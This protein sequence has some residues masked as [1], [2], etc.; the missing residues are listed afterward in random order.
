MIMCSATRSA[1]G[2]KVCVS[3]TRGDSQTVKVLATRHVPLIVGSLEWTLM[4]A[5]VQ[6]LS[7]LQGDIENGESDQ[8]WLDV[9]L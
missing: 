2:I 9:L 4:E 6:L 3:G 8:L 5:I 7:E 1:S